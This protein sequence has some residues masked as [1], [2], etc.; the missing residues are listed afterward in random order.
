MPGL[1]NGSAFVLGLEADVDVLDYRATAPFPT[2]NGDL[3]TSL[4]NNVEGSVRGRLGIAFDRTL[5]YAT[6]GVAFADYKTQ[7]FA[8]IPGFGNE[9]FSKTQV[10][11]TVGAGLEYAIANNWSLRAEYRYTDFGTFTDPTTAFY[12]SPAVLYVRHSEI[13]NRIQAGF[14]YK[15]GGPV[16]AKY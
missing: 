5:I 16:V 4:R 7:Y 14:S 10:G 9:E 12:I 6:G 1:G 2:F 13:E 8:I 11:W 3:L 15:F